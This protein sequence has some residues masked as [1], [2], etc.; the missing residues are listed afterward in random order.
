MQTFNINLGKT[1]AEL[2]ALTELTDLGAMMYDPGKKIAYE[3]EWHT[4]V[5]TTV[6][7]PKA[8]NTELDYYYNQTA[9]KKNTKYCGQLYWK[10][11]LIITDG[12]T[13]DMATP[14]K[15]LDSTKKLISG[16]DFNNESGL[17]DSIFYTRGRLNSLYGFTTKS[18]AVSEELSQILDTT[19]IRSTLKKMPSLVQA[20]P[21][22]G[23]DYLYSGSQSYISSEA[24]PDNGFNIMST[25][26]IDKTV[27]TPS[28]R[29]FGQIVAGIYSTS[30]YFNITDNDDSLVLK[31][32]QPEN[33]TDDL[34]FYNFVL[35]TMSSNTPDYIKK[36]FPQA[37]PIGVPMVIAPSFVT[38]NSD[39]AANLKTLVAPFIFYMLGITEVPE[40]A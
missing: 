8:N 39:P 11:G 7:K 40:E 30:G 28:T 18:F 2:Q 13:S 4:I 35:G 22:S 25:S 14:S 5:P 27:G 24:S 33:T 37:L 3:K 10:A 12:S 36:Y 16:G 31:Y 29:V 32:S 23:N 9:L 26:T 21:T 19:D 6:I 15:V 1:K 38:T 20:A 34:R 17:V